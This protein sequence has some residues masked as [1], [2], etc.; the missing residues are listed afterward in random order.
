MLTILIFLDFLGTCGEMQLQKKKSLLCSKNS[1]K[2]R[3]HH[4]IVSFV[5]LATSALTIYNVSRLISTGSIYKVE[6]AKWRMMQKKMEI[7]LAL[8][9][10]GPSVSYQ[11]HDI[12][13]SP[14]TS[15]IRYL[16]EDFRTIDFH[17]PEQ[18]NKPFVQES[19]ETT[20]S[21]HRN[22][23]GYHPAPYYDSSYGYQETSSKYYN[24]YD[25]KRYDQWYTYA[26]NAPP[27]FDNC[28]S[29]AVDSS[30]EGYT[31]H[32]CSQEDFLGRHSYMNN[33]AENSRIESNL[34]RRDSNAKHV[35][36]HY[37]TQN[38]MFMTSL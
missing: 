35:P 1:K 3:P 17:T 12:V 11:H 33:N 26:D 19:E 15:D 34:Q 23:S 36:Y 21:Y 31:D 8:S 18:Y 10:N 2:V 6:M 22:H 7:E 29:V 32:F 24:Y 27:R 5:Y 25:T 37:P 38:G 16:P 14:D 20:S 28:G 13:K 30:S 4:F 9:N